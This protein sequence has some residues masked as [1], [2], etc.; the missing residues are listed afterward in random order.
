MCALKRPRL[1][2][3]N[4]AVRPHSNSSSTAATTTIIIIIM[5]C[6][7]PSTYIL[8]FVARQPW[9]PSTGR[10]WSAESHKI[11]IWR[12]LNQTFSYK[13]M[14]GAFAPYSRLLYRRCTVH[15]M[16]ACG[17]AWHGGILRTLPAIPFRICV[18][19]SS[20]KRNSKLST[21]DSKL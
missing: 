10:H 1:H 4:D 17:Y 12:Q 9:R 11:Y 6:P 2:I 5:Q 14:F 13:R 16:P 20:G 8:S 7:W 18:N 19:A 21:T 15:D 3:V